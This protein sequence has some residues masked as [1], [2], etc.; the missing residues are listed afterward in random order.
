VRSKLYRK[1]ARVPCSPP[2]TKV[3]ICSFER[4]DP[5]PP[6]R[7]TSTCSHKVRPV[8]GQ[9]LA[10]ASLLAKPWTSVVPPST[11]GESKSRKN[12]KCDQRQHSLAIATGR[13]YI[14]TFMKPQSPFF[15]PCHSTLI[16]LCTS[17]QPAG[18][19]GDMWRRG[20]DPAI[21]R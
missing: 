14:M 11:V 15:M 3:R 2:A 13:L 9:Q 4:L 12:V 7:L 1:H 17:R 18:V 5:A 8:A 10:A 16:R 19:C 21:N 20:G 6:A